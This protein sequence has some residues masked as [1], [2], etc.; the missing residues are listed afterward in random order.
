MK[1]QFTDVRVPIELLNFL[2]QG[3][4]PQL[5]TKECLQRTKQQNKEVAPY[6]RSLSSMIGLELIQMD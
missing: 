4:N 1:S 3:K 2:D 6:P 5:Y